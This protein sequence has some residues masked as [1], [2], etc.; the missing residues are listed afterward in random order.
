MNADGLKSTPNWD[1][2]DQMGW[3]AGGGPRTPYCGLTRIVA[4]HEEEL[5]G[6]NKA[7]LAAGFVNS[8]D[9]TV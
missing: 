1:D 8:A 4:D 7:H 3:M 2:W 5:P 9:S 6:Q